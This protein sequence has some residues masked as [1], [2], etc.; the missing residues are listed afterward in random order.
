MEFRSRL[1]TPNAVCRTG[2]K[3]GCVLG[4][5][6]KNNR[7]LRLRIMQ[8]QPRGSDGPLV[9]AFHILDVGDN[10]YSACLEAL[11]GRAT[12]ADQVART[13]RQASPQCVN[14]VNSNLLVA[15]KE[16]AFSTPG[17]RERMPG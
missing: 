10:K 9:G 7:G 4:G 17:S 8:D 13:I 14:I 6:A 3:T 1:Q 16:S 12:D 15:E 2:A 5:A 11:V